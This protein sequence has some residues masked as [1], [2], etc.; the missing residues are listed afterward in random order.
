MFDLQRSCQIDLLLIGV[1]VSTE[2]PRAQPNET[3]R[4]LRIFLENVHVHDNA[5]RMVQGVKSDLP[6]GLFLESR[7]CEGHVVWVPS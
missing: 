3:D 4:G 5:E 1:G 2:S 6:G 7:R